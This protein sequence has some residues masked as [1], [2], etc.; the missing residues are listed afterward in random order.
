MPGLSVDAMVP[1]KNR[2]HIFG[3]PHAPSR[4]RE[5]WDELDPLKRASNLKRAPRPPPSSPTVYVE[6]YQ[7]TRANVR[8]LPPSPPPLPP[9]P[10]PPGYVQQYP[11]KLAGLVTPPPLPR[12]P[13]SVWVGKY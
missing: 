9:P 5:L 8:C 10:P 11:P 2:P 3:R 6:Q 1:G 4:S 7:P 12:L 13:P